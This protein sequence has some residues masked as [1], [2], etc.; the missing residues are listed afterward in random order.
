MARVPPEEI[1]LR[2]LR[3]L[4]AK[5]TETQKECSENSEERRS[6]LQTV[7]VL[8]AFGLYNTIPSYGRLEPKTL[9]AIWKLPPQTSADIQKTFAMYGSKNNI[10]TVITL[11]SKKQTLFLNAISDAFDNTAIFSSL[12]QLL[13]KVKSEPLQKNIQ[14]LLDNLSTAKKMLREL[15]KNVESSKTAITGDVATLRQLSEDE[16][17][18]LDSLKK[19]L[20]QGITL[21]ASSP[22]RILTGSVC[23]PHGGYGTNPCV[24][25]FA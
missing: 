4:S 10:E 7:I 20:Y 16:E 11:L 5:I 21:P 14:Q 9:E 17:A 2:Y 15:S 24:L 22:E 8:K 1:A 25:C 12:Q 18:L 3:M 6:L 19:T 23:L 13:T